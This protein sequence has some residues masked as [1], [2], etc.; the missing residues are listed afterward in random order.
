MTPC[1]LASG[2]R[3][4][5]VT[6]FTFRMLESGG[7]NQPPVRL[8]VPWERGYSIDLPKPCGSCALSAV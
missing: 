3:R 1:R 7:D 2:Y 8:A 6:A 5:G 4:F